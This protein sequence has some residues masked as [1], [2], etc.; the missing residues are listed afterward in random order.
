MERAACGGFLEGLV[1]AGDEVF[2]QFWVRILN[3]YL[4]LDC[5]CSSYKLLLR[6]GGVFSAAIMVIHW[7]SNHS[8]AV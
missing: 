2:S 3:P 7:S 1:A 6:S 5:M 4:N 8:S